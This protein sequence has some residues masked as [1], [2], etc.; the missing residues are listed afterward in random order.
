[1]NEPLTQIYG[2]DPFLLKKHINL[3]LQFAMIPSFL[4]DLLAVL[5]YGYDWNMQTI[6]FTDFLHSTI[7]FFFI[8]LI[9]TKLFILFYCHRYKEMMERS[10][11]T[12]TN[13]DS[14]QELHFIRYSMW[15]KFDAGDSI[16]AYQYYDYYP[17]KIT[18]IQ[19]QKNGSLILHGQ[20]VCTKH[21]LT[22]LDESDNIC[23][24]TTK[25]RFCIP[26]YFIGLEESI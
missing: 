10:Y 19:N 26:S 20:I 14:E 2:P 12:L 15:Q 6:T 21:Q 9:T 8:N 5:A 24:T 3:R 13:H 16:S 4:L 22:T 18:S 7:F 1:M 25:K 23:G 11:L 17:Q